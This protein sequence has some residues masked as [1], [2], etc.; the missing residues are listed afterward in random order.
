MNHY[1]TSI[2]EN[3]VHFRSQSVGLAINVSLPL[4]HG[5]FNEMQCHNE[6]CKCHGRYLLFNNDIPLQEFVI[7]VASELRCD[8]SVRLP[9]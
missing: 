3:I 1:E 6:N 7:N 8:H 5:A 2:E 4:S 9:Y